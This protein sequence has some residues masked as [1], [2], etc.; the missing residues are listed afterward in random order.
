MSDQEIREDDE[1]E[2]HGLGSKASRRGTN[3]RGADRGGADDEGHGVEATGSASKADRRGVH[4]GG[5]DR[6]V[7]DSAA[8]DSRPGRREAA[9]AFLFVRSSFRAERVG[10][11][12]KQSNTRRP[13]IVLERV[14]CRRETRDD[15]EIARVV[16]QYPL[17][18]SRAKQQIDGDRGLVRE[19]PEQVHLLEREVRPLRAVQDLENPECPFVVEEGR[20]HQPARDVAGSLRDVTREP[21]VVS[22]VFEDERGARGEHPPGDAVLRGEAH[23]EQ[24]LLALADDRLEHELVRRLV[25]QQDRR[26]LGPEDRARDLY[27]RAEQSAK[28]LGGA[29]DSRSHCSAQIVRLGHWPPPTLVAV[30]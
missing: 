9:R 14:D 16:L 8:E 20:R 11:I 28:R 6:R 25:E 21:R 1:V 2:A 29:D 30:R 10:E 27:E 15:R 22:H 24:G 3:R 19:E 18:L 7:A 4:G 17:G 5:P 23:S 26:R 12:A 13:P